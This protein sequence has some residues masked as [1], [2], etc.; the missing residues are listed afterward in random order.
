MN[1]IPATL[2]QFPNIQGLFLSHNAIASIP[3][4]LFEN[5]RLVMLWLAANQLQDDSF[6]DVSH[7]LPLK[8]VD[9]RFN[10]L[11][12]PPQFL[13]RCPDITYCN[14]FGNPFPAMLREKGTQWN[15]WYD[16]EQEKVKKDEEWTFHSQDVPYYLTTSVRAFLDTI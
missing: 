10:Q 15:Y 13:T 8:E 9:L 1:E 11:T 7:D 6:P 16:I 12:H 5:P 2:R 3:P 4:W 14:T